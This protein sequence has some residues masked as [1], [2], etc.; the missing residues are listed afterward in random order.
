M[1]LLVCFCIFVGKAVAQTNS[2]ALA[3]PDVTIKAYL[4]PD[5]DIYVGQL[6]RL[7]I[8]V[9]TSTWFTRAPRYP[10]LQMDGAIALMPDQ[11]GVNFSTTDRGKTRVGQRQRYVIIPQRAGRLA[12]PSLTVTLGVSVDGKPSEAINLKTKPIELTAILPPGAEGLDQIVTSQKISV[13][14]RY[15][16][17]FEDFKVGDAITRTVTLRG[18]NTFALALPRTE[19]LGVAGTRVY[20]GQPRL[21]DS[22]NRGQYRAVRTD[23]ATYVFEQEGAFTLPAIAV[24]WWNPEAK[25]IEEQVLPEVALTIS[26]NHAYQPNATLELDR[27]DLGKSIEERIAELLEWI[28]SNI[29]WLTLAAIAVYFVRLAWRRFGVALVAEMRGYRERL[30]QSEA[31]YFRDFARAYRAGDKSTAVKRFWRWLDRLT[32]D[33]QAAC[34][35]RLARKTGASEIL[36]RARAVARAR[37]GPPD[38][39]AEPASPTLRQMKQFRRQLRDVGPSSAMAA[40]SLNP[41]SQRGAD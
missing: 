6:A 34:L 1:A 25:R 26:A 33:D 16:R 13:E 28:R 38:K 14:E 36:T 9:S 5:G 18:E 2:E 20:P 12:I 40:D 35:D 11:L 39:H 27:R 32:P 31:R 21:N 23:S 8:E 3:G 37:Y 17:S 41:R 22:I 10:E 29:G 7:W 19:F 24:R 30:R 4:E 15:D